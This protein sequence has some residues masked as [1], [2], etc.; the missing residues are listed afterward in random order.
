MLWIL[1]A[2]LNVIHITLPDGKKNVSILD[3]MEKT[4]RVFVLLLF[5]SSLIEG[6]RVKKKIELDKNTPSS[7][8]NSEYETRKG[9][10][11]NMFSLFSVVSF[12]NTDCT[13]SSETQGDF[14]LKLG[15]LSISILGFQAPAL[16][17]MSVLLRAEMLMETVPR[18]SESAAAL[19]RPA[20]PPR[21][22][23]GHTLST[24]PQA[25]SPLSA[26]SSYPP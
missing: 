17:P 9:R 16:P 2:F 18:G 20:T 1:I 7:N 21:A 3:I 26:A 12:E 4:T 25:P 5:S 6:L 8:L 11:L 19:Q 23:T 14:E 24:P 22:R 10:F 15:N 13:T